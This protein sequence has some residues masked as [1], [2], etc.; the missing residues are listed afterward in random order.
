MIIGAVGNCDGARPA[1]RQAALGYDDPG[2]FDMSKMNK[3]WRSALAAAII[4]VSAMSALGAASAS[5]AVRIGVVVPITPPAPRYEPVP[6]YPRAYAAG[7]VVWQP[8]YWRWTGR[9]Y[10][11]VAGHYERIPRHRHHWVDGHWAQRPGGWVW[12]GGHW[13]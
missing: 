10:V 12:V 3:N 8:G 1:S 4:G 13:R 2:T 9:D 7:R 5:A 11:W 6:V